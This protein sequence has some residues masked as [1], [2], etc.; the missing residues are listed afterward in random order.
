MLALDPS[1]L[2]DALRRLIKPGSPDLRKY[3]ENAKR[4][5]RPAASFDIA[6]SIL[7]HLPPLGEP[8]IWQSLHSQHVQ[9]RMSGRLKSAIRIR[10]LRG[11]LSKTILPSPVRRRLARLGSRTHDLSKNVK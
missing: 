7:H 10:R 6:A 5:S 3:L 11:R 9:R 1:T 4:I 8:G 2:I